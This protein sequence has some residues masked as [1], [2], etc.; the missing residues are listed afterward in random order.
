MEP[1]KFTALDVA[2]SL[3]QHNPRL[4]IVIPCLNEAKTLSG[5]IERCHGAILGSTITAEIVIVDNGS[6]D[7]SISIAKSRGARIV[8]CPK[9]GYGNALIKGISESKGDIILI[10]DADGTYDFNEM[11]R[12]ITQLD[13]G[14]DVVIGTRLGGRIEHGA[15]PFLHRWLGTPVLTQLLNL[16]FR[17]RIS[18]CNS[19]MR[20]FTKAAFLRMKL[21]S[22]GM[23]FASEMIIKAGLLHLRVVEIPISYYRDRRDRPPSL[24]T[25]QDGWKHLRLIMMYAPDYLFTFPGTIFFI[26]GLFLTV[27]TYF[28][29]RIVIYQTSYHFMLFGCLLIILGFQMITMSFIAKIHSLVNDS[30][31]SKNFIDGFAKHFT[32]ERGVLTGLFL[33]LVGLTIDIK[34]LFI[35]I[36]SGYGSINLINLVAIASTLMIVGA[37]TIFSS[38]LISL[39]QLH[40]R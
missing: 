34:I 35:W 38:F 6:T 22:S 3:G 33:F 10:G 31:F 15:M 40:K 28:K 30:I 26:T 25:W 36:S 9:R 11:A 24:K 39:I 27:I 12:F 19:G 23:E 1:E 17:L 13:R 21:F 18:D 16:F 2:C 7:S 4:S 5:V 14:N 37:Q 29:I 32:L 8:H 20:C